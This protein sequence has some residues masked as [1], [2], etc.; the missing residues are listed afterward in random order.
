MIVAQIM[1]PCV[2]GSNCYLD[3]AA[4]GSIGAWLAAA[5]TLIAVFVPRFR[6][7]KRERVALRRGLAQIVPEV[8]DLIVTVGNLDNY[9]EVVSTQEPMRMIIPKDFAFVQRLSFVAPSIPAAAKYEAIYE[10][11]GNLTAAIS[12]WNRCVDSLPDGPDLATVLRSGNL[13]FA[14]SRLSAKIR[15]AA[16]DLLS[17]VATEFPDIA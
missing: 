9:R 16:N 12:A 6:D 4:I 11:F 13:N 3:W 14:M 7:S 15:S 2:S 5:A 8:R 10:R 17:L 1:V